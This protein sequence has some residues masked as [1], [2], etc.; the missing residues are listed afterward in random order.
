MKQRKCYDVELLRYLLR[1]I[2]SADRD[3]TEGALYWVTAQATNRRLA[4][5]I[6]AENHL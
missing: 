4:A 3:Y 5:A 6:H 2:P 1:S